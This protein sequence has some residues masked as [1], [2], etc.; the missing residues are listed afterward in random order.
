MAD[1]LFR[2]LPPDALVVTGNGTAYTGTFQAMQIK[3]G[4]RVFTNQACASMGYDLPAA[5]GACIAHSGPVVLMTGDGSI[6]MNLQE[7]Q[8]IANYR[9]PIKIFMLD[10]RG[11]LSIRITQDAYFDGRHIASGPELG[12]TC[13]DVCRIA[14]AYGL[15]AARLEDETD[16]EK[17]LQRLLDLPGPLVCNVHMDPNQTVLPKLSSSVGPD[18]RMISHRWRICI[19]FCPARNSTRT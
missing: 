8:T 2:L 4:M 9:L 10:N 11:Y 13:P 17:N 19:R 3:K 15:P 18:G 7:L 1:E 12:V 6:Q 14:E 16:L 5:I